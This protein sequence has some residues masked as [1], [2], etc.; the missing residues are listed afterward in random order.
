MGVEINEEKHQGQRGLNRLA[1]TQLT[2][3]CCNLSFPKHR[4]GKK[5]SS[6][7][8]NGS[9][10]THKQDGKN[11]KKEGFEN[12]FWKKQQRL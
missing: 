7:E 11:L 5:N 6:D 12:I 4:T 10:W 3:S 2:S 1:I 9:Q 8:S